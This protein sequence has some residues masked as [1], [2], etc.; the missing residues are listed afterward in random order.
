MGGMLVLLAFLLCGVFT[1][2]GLLRREAGIVRVWTGLCCGFILMMWLPALFAFFLNFT[3]LAQ[4][5]GLGVAAALAVAA[6]L[7]ARAKRESA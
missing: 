2:D 3:I 7:R 5:L 1:M 6:Q 4:C